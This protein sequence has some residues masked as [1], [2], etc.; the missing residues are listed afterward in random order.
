MKK[1]FLAKLL[2]LVMVLTL[3]PIAA[4]AANGDDNSIY[5][6]K[7][8][9]TVV[10]T[11]D[12]APAAP[13]ADVSVK[14]TT[15]ADGSVVA[16]TTVKAEVNGTAATATVDAAMVT[17][18][19]AQ[20][21]DSDIIVL[22]VNAPRNATEAVLKVAGSALANLARQSKASLVVESSIATITVAN[23][24]L[25]GLASGATNVEVSAKVVG[26][27][28]V[29]TVAK[30]GKDADLSKGVQVSL[31]GSEDTVVYIVGADGSETEADSTFAD[32]NVVV[33]LTGTAT[34]RLG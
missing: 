19:L 11:E 28:I 34:I 32:G 4:L 23:E 33:T 29:I 18:L 3:V 27:T 1:Q 20:A 5:Y 12:P 15:N 13:K 2:V 6:N 9:D 30:D 16:T 8:H 14:T 10:S 31:K 24:D 25:A 22:S 21:K 17:A 26:D 7:K